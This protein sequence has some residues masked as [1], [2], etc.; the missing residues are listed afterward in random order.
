MKLTD[1]SINVVKTKKHKW[2]GRKQGKGERWYRGGS[3]TKVRRKKQ[4]KDR[5]W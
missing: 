4:V 3:E 1:I 2:N 5:R